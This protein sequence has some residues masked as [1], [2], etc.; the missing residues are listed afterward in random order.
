MTQ[1]LT[2][3]C[4]RQQTAAGF[5]YLQRSVQLLQDEELAGRQMESIHGLC[6]TAANAH[7]MHNLRC[8]GSS[9]RSCYRFT[10]SRAWGI[11]G[12]MGLREA[13]SEANH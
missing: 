6:P 4:T 13:H 12:A 5:A 1:Q 3:K 11:C 8:L 7:N 2:S 10:A 9:F